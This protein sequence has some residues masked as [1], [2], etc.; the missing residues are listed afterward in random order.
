MEQASTTTT[1]PLGGLLWFH[2]YLLLRVQ[3]TLIN[4][5]KGSELSYEYIPISSDVCIAFPYPPGYDTV[6][7]GRYVYTPNGKR[8]LMEPDTRFWVKRK[9]TTQTHLEAYTNLICET[10]N[11]SKRIFALLQFIVDIVPMCY[12]NAGLYDVAQN[13]IREVSTIRTTFDEILTSVGISMDSPFYGAWNLVWNSKR[14]FFELCNQ[15]GQAHSY[16]SKS[17]L[18]DNS[19]IR[20]GGVFEYIW[21]KDLRKYFPDPATGEWAILLSTPAERSST[22]PE[23][24][25]DIAATVVYGEGLGVQTLVQCMLQHMTKKIEKTTCTRVQVSELTIAAQLFTTALKDFERRVLTS[26]EIVLI[27]TKSAATIFTALTAE[28]RQYVCANLRASTFFINDN[29]KKC[30]ATYVW[31]DT[32]MQILN[33]MS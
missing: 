3:T 33:K 15:R 25:T 8:I 6:E 17:V 21:D 20:Q 32:S 9:K 5:W 14:A 19:G 23:M 18:L 26:E 30:P 11:V 24:F 31:N 2:A 27:V 22:P 4:K 29:Y 10:H 16:T 12:I 1:K 13:C 7:K 28:H